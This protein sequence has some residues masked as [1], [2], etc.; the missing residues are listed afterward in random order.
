MKENKL[1][2]KNVRASDELRVNRSWIVKIDTLEHIQYSAL[3]SGAVADTA[4]EGKLVC[5]IPSV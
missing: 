4:R 3:Q 1:V 2:S 5:L